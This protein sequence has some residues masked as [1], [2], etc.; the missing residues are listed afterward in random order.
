MQQI[1]Q[2]YILRLG[3]MVEIYKNY[4]IRNNPFIII[5]DQLIG[6]LKEFLTVGKKKKLAQYRVNTQIYKI[7]K[8]EQIIAQSNE[9]LFLQGRKV[10]EIR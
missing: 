3:Q 4:A 7:K 6:M 5:R 10:N 2:N 9:H 1:I 8:M